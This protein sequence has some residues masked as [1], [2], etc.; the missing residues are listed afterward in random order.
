MHKRNRFLGTACVA[1]VAL[2]AG[3]A[4]A[5]TLTG[6]AGFA[7][8]TYTHQTFSDQSGHWNAATFGVGGAIPVAEIPNLNFQVGASYAHAWSDEY[9]HFSP[10]FCDPPTTSGS[11]CAA[12]FSD[13]EEVWHFDFS[14]FLAYPGS[15]WGMNLNYETITHFGHITNGG[16]FAEWYLNDEITLMAKGG[17]LSTG[18]TPYGGHG[19]YL[20]GA[21]IFYP[22]PDV[23]VRGSV[24]WTDVTTGGSALT[25]YCIHCRGD[26]GA[27]QYGINAEWLPNEEWGVAVN[28]GFTYS[29]NNT[30]NDE[31]NESIWKIGLRWYTGGGSLAERHRNGTL[32]PWLPGTG[33]TR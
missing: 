27:V 30:F 8:G 9:T 2:A 17:Y 11:A 20:S 13:S 12:D 28:G 1:A 29:Q 15:R 7:D 21:A 16:A 4:A 25:N 32:N 26:D 10:N 14:P 3:P 18:G 33:V 6:F 24:G 31:Y 5:D 19:H 23:A 22:V